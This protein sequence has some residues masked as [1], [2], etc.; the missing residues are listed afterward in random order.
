MAQGLLK[1]V[2]QRLSQGSPTSDEKVKKKMAEVMEQIIHIEDHSNVPVKVDPKSH[3]LLTSISAKANGIRG[4]IKSQEWALRVPEH[5]PKGDVQDIAFM[6]MK[7]DELQLIVDKGIFDYGCGDC[8]IDKFRKNNV[9]IGQAAP[10]VDDKFINNSLSNNDRGKSMSQVDKIVNTV[11]R[12][13][14]GFADQFFNR[15]GVDG[16]LVS[17]SLF[18]NIVGSLAGVGMDI[19]FNPGFSL[20]AET[21]AGLGVMFASGKY[22]NDPRAKLEWTNVGAF[23]F[24]RLLRAGVAELSQATSQLGSL[25]RIALSNPKYALQAPFRTPAEIQSIVESRTQMVGGLNPTRMLNAGTSLRQ[26]IV[27]TVEHEAPI[28]PARNFPTF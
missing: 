24:T 12:S 27:P 25:G 7:L 4:I 3:Q 17:S 13:Y 2:Q 15:L 18:S 6:R 9:E 22:V 20:V 14:S 16:Q 21:L 8:T 26:V 1:E 28:S 5:T 19:L 23:M 10:I 11:F